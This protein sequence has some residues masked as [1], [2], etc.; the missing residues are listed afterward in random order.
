MQANHGLCTRCHPLTSLYMLPRR[1]A[2]PSPQCDTDSDG[3]LSAEELVQAVKAW[4]PHVEPEYLE[5]I[6]AK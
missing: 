4:M 1:A 2:T 3:A 5:A 6:F